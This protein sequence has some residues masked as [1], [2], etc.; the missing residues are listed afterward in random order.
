MIELA[1][2][3]V[4]VLIT[5]SCLP[6]LESLRREHGRRAAKSLLQSVQ[7]DRRTLGEVVSRIPH[8]SSR[9]MRTTGASLVDLP[10]SFRP[11]VVVPMAAA[12]ALTLGGP[13]VDNA[14]TSVAPKTEC[15]WH[16]NSA[17]TVVHL[18]SH[19]TTP[20]I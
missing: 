7:S 13:V 11:V 19:R 16:V 12:I 18:S 1:L 17:A 15:A 8:G 5:L 10:R 9:G 6:R 4:A 2:I 3:N 20:H 14:A